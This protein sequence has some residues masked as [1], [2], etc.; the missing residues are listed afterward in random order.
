MCH[1]L[2]EPDIFRL[3]YRD[4][5]IDCAGEAIRQVARGDAVNTG[6]LLSQLAKGRVPENDREHFLKIAKEEIAAL[7][8]GHYARYR[9]RPHTQH[10][11]I[12]A[13]QYGFSGN[14]SFS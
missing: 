12:Y 9:L 4:A 7:H 10:P 5:L 3:R 1:T 13:Q 14:Y 6:D 8:E 11:L 2:A